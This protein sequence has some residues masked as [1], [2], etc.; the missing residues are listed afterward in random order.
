[1]LSYVDDFRLMLVITVLCAPLL[2]LMRTPKKKT[3]GE[4]L[5]VAVD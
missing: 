2:L 4:D 1:M 3:G 5:H